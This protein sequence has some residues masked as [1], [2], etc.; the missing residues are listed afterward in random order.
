MPQMILEKALYVFISNE[1]MI[2][3]W[4]SGALPFQSRKLFVIQDAEK[5]LTHGHLGFSVAFGEPLVNLDQC[6]ICTQSLKKTNGQK[7]GNL[8]IYGDAMK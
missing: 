8:N 6:K 5:I 4:N 1:C 2:D 7:C 3:E